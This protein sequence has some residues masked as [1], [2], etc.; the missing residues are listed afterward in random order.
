[1][2]FI[3]F[4]LKK[5]VFSLLLSLLPFPIFINLSIH[6]FSIC[7]T[8]WSTK[9]VANHFSCYSDYNC[10]RQ[11]PSVKE[12]GEGKSHIQTEYTTQCQFQL[13]MQDIDNTCKMR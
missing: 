2:I 1:M 7:F 4:N 3:Y 8:V 5:K 13:K 9:L 12:V 10:L 6:L 11:T